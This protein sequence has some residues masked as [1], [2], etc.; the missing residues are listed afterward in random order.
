MKLDGRDPDQ[1]K[2]LSVAEQVSNQ[3]ALCWSRFPSFLNKKLSLKA[4]HSVVLICLASNQHKFQ[5]QFPNKIPTRKFRT[6]LY[7]RKLSPQF[8]FRHF[9]LRNLGR[10]LMGGE[11]LTT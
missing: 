11:M 4:Y 5:C 7:T 6:T 9:R 8:N 2:R 3:L 1:S 10:T